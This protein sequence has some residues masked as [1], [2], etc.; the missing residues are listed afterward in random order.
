MPST[1]QGAVA[2]QALLIFFLAYRS[3]R[4]YHGRPLSPVR[5]FVFPAFTTLIF[6]ATEVETAASVPVF[7]PLWAIVDG[8]AFTAA[9]VATIPLAPRFVTVT[10]SR[11]GSFTYRYGIELIA[12]YLGLWV[13]RLALAL[14]YDPSSL[15]FDFSI[16]STLTSSPATAMLVVQTLFAVSTGVVV[17]RSVGTYVLYR[18]ER[19]RS[20]LASPE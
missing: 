17:G 18:K 1:L 20:P 10:S 11:D 16:P 14:V 8:V 2:V 3:L 15:A 12:F 13:V 7:Y 6:L 9:L 19:A 5:L 4:L